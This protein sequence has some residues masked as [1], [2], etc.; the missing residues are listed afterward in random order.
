MGGQRGLGR[1]ERLALGA[2]TGQ[3]AARSSARPPDDPACARPPYPGLPSP[4]AK[5]RRAN[6]QYQCQR[7]GPEGIDQRRATVCTSVTSVS[8]SSRRAICTISGLSE[9]RPLATNTAS[10]AAVFRASAP[11]PYTVSV[12]KA[13]VSPLRMQRCGA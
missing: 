5:G 2:A 13:T 12:G 10:T 7:A 11:S 3:S 4:A 1:P 8:R 9:G 6:R